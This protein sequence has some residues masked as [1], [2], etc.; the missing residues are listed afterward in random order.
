MAARFWVGGTGAWDNA[1]TSHWSATTGGGSGA[2]VPTSADNVTF[3][4]NSGTA[5]TVT[6]QTATANANTITINKSDLTLTHSG[7]GSTVVGAVTLTTGTLNTNGQTCSWGDFQSDN[8]NTR[9]ILAGS[10]SIT[11][12]GPTW[13]TF[14]TTGLTHSMASS[15]LTMASGSG[16]VRSAGT[17]G[18]VIWS[19]VTNAEGLGFTCTTLTITGSATKTGY[20]KIG[21]APSGVTVTGTCTLGGNS[22]QGVNRLLVQSTVVGTQ[23]TIT[24][25]AYVIAGD[26][27]FMDINLAYSGGASWTNT[28]NAYIGD[29]LGN[30][31]AV[32]TNANAPA[33]QTATGTASFTWSTHGWTS[34]VPLPQDDVVIALGFGATQTVTMDMPRIGKNINWTGT[35]GNPNWNAA[36][37]IAQFGS[38]TIAAGM[39]RNSTG[40]NA[41][42]F[43]GRGNHTIT[44]AGMALPAVTIDAAGGTYTLQDNYSSGNGFALINGT[45]DLNNK[46]L[47]SLSAFTSNGTAT[48]SLV[49]G[50]GT[51]YLSGPAGAIWDVSS[52]LTLSASSST[53][54]ISVASA[55]TRT[56]AGGGKTYGTLTYTV[57]NSP[58]ALA[59]TGA[60]TFNTVNVG[61][62]RVLTMPS[63]T[64]NTITNFNVNGATNGYMYLPGVSGHYA[65]A[66]DS[67]ALSITGDIDIRCKVALDDW[68][69]AASTALVTKFGPAKLAYR[70]LVISTGALFFSLSSSGVDLTDV[71]SSV[72]TGLANGSI[73]WVRVTWRASDGRVQYFLSDDGSS[74]SQLGTNLTIAY[75]SIYDGA[76][77]LNIGL[78]GNG[79]YPAAGKFYRAQIRNNVLDD[80]SGIVFDADFTTKTVGAN[81]FTESSSNAATVSITGNL[82]QAGDGRIIAA[83]STPGTKWFVN[84]AAASASYVDVQ[85][86]T[87]SGAGAPIDDTTGGVN[88]G[89]NV[90]WLFVAGGSTGSGSTFMRLGIG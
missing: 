21:N 80:G 10:S 29:A 24:A 76:E 70:F 42:S 5:A 88:R 39:A 17:F 35:T 43:A 78:Q 84:T 54:L 19:G 63:A 18:T 23:R 33:T 46:D 15:T 28:G 81:T 74:W 67:A 6:I 40:G 8:S 27:D 32:T 82:A 30:G 22:T 57:A 7:F 65:S 4:A 2:S 77:S 25:A 50:T 83:S 48:R 20:L 55:N 52:S 38:L 90:G 68:T 66:P 64:A 72:A 9:S 87:A 51:I 45:F 85:D 86:S 34:R 12:T 31:G 16:Y 44:T 14:T 79:Q 47:N 62:G 11:I 49:A 13:N 89:N 3:D 71:Q 36:L 37:S 75:A 58:G 73:K 60:S 41:V 69:P 26:V 1:D 56:F 59:I 53:I 61:S